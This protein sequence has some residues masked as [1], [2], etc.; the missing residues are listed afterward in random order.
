VIE[1][2]D[3]LLLFQFEMQLPSLEGTR[4][5]QILLVEFYFEYT[6]KIKYFNKILIKV[7]NGLQLYEKD[8][9]VL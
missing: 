8:Q 2:K 7:F 6:K 4:G 9:Q 5:N 1:E 3:R